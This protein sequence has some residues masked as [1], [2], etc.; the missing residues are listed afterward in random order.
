MTSLLDFHHVLATA[1][2]RAAKRAA[3]LAALPCGA[4][5]PRST[6]E[7]TCAFRLDDACKHRQRD[8]AE[9]RAD[10]ERQRRVRRLTAAGIVPG[11]DPALG[12]VIRNQ[13]EPRRA[14][15]AV[16][17]ALERDGLRW[18]LLSGPPGVGKT[19]AGLLAVAQ[20][21][22]LVVSA[23]DLASPRP[24]ESWASAGVRRPPGAWTLADAAGAAVL[25]VDDL[26]QER[27][28]D[29]AATQVEAAI[30]SREYGGRLLTILTSNAGPDVLGERYG[31]R[32]ASRISGAKGL[33]VL[34]GGHP[35]GRAR[36][37]GRK[38]VT[39]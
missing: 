28:S 22:G 13:L 26:G 14:T 38:A 5:A 1:H 3:D 23:H 35:D 39:R 24:L 37:P 12:L 15:R 8:E 18:L 7:R 25:L 4:C 11:D 31:E 30:C 10:E 34:C 27:S 17:T 20:R 2:D 29:F 21:G 6:V 33:V 16:E 32:F 19:L 9:R 36:K